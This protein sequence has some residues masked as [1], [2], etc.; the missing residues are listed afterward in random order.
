MEI[1]SELLEILKENLK[2]L[3]LSLVCESTDQP[4]LIEPPGR[5]N[6]ILEGNLNGY[7]DYLSSHLLMPTRF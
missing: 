7:V 2:L 3:V 1:D 6:R 5:L 4:L